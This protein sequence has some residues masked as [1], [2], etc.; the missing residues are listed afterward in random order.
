MKRVLVSVL[1]MTLTVAAVTM[2]MM[3]SAKA[4]TIIS[5]LRCWRPTKAQPGSQ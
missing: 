2:S 4:E 1:M 3:R 5:R